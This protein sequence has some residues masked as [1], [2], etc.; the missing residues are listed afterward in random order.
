MAEK[1]LNV[2][3]LHSHDTGRYV[4]PYGYAVATPN[5]Q[6][7]AEEGVLFRQAFCAGPT[8]SPSRA[9]LLTGQYPH[10]N[11]M[12]G[13]AHR[14]FRLNDYSCHLVNT[15]KKAGYKTFLSGVQH[16]AGENMFPKPWKTIGYDG[17]LGAAGPVHLQAGKFLS[18]NPP[19]PFFLSAGFYETHRPFPRVEQEQSRYCLAPE[20]LPDTPETRADM[21][22]FKLLASRLDEEIGHL[23]E[24]LRQTKLLKRTLIICTTDHGPAFPRMK[25]TLYDGGIRVMLIMRG[26]EPFRGGRV[27]DELVSQVDI[28]P[29]LCRYLRL[30]EPDWLAGV[31]LLPLV[32]GHDP[33]REEIFAEINYHAAYEPSRCVRTRRW[34]YLKR[35]HNHETP[36]LPNTDAGPSKSLWLQHGWGSQRLAREE[37]YDLLFD[38]NETSNLAESPG[39]REVLME[40]QT[41]LENW[42][43]ATADPLLAGDIPLPETARLNDPDGLNPDEPLLPPGRR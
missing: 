12:L 32:E 6:R 18:Q 5:L 37:L 41:R 31:S 16:E 20:P 36:V 33:V 7:L 8:C 1:R 35:Y 10:Q 29:T 11:G 4:Q 27:V 30:P 13:L 26:P 43:K 23:L 25:C 15:L 24:I 2:V 39:A 34:K 42:M 9:A 19:E 3:Y 22:G 28:F 17:F 38:P 21:A 14:G 40:M